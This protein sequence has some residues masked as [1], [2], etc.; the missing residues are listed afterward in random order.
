VY[1]EFVKGYFEAAKKYK[2]GTF[3]LHVVSDDPEMNTI[4][5]SPYVA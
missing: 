2:P 1:D 4:R 5:L 3:M